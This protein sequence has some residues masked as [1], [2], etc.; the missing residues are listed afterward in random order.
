MPVIMP[1]TVVAV[2]LGGGDPRDPLARHHGV[3]AKALVPLDGRPLAARVLAALRDCPEVRESVYVG[4][5][6]PSLADLRAAAL[7][8]GRQLWASLALGLG[9]ALPRAEANDGARLLLI[10]A[11]LPWLS[12]ATLSRFLQQAHDH[13]GDAALIYPVIPRP[14]AERQFPGQQRTWVKLAGLQP[15][16]VAGPRAEVTGGNAMLLRPEAVPAL[17][18]VAE[19]GYRARKNPLALARLLGWDA[20]AALLRGRLQQGALERRVGALMKLEVRALVTP[21]AALGADVDR[22]EQLSRG[23]AAIPPT[24]EEEP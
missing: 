9:A 12:G 22:P 8:A 24:P 1:F 23:P 17:L 19:R 3:A 6:D 18:E 13:A 14:L 5:D 15:A 20:V 7:P 16:S 21:E 11:D 10:S 4:I 2:V